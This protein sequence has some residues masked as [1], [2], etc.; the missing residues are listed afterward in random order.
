[1]LLYSLALIVAPV[2]LSEPHVEEEPMPLLLE[3]L[4]PY[5][6]SPRPAVLPE[7]SEEQTAKEEVRRNPVVQFVKETVLLAVDVIGILTQLC[8]RLVKLWFPFLQDVP[9]VLV[10]CTSQTVAAMQSMV[11]KPLTAPFRLVVQSRPAEEE[12]KP[13]IVRAKQT[14]NTVWQEVDARLQSVTSCEGLVATLRELD[15]NVDKN[16]CESPTKVVFNRFN[17][18]TLPEPYRTILVVIVAVILALSFSLATNKL[19]QC[20]GATSSIFDIPIK[21]EE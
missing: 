16:V 19:T 6:I 10:D 3:K 14:N 18:F 15:L 2:L 11:W 5:H 12:V 1:M 7:V 9:W 8:I 21:Q 20:E 13:T 4:K 17:S